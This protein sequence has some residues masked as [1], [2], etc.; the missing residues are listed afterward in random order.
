M[1]LLKRAP[2]ECGSWVWELDEVAPPGLVSA[3]DVAARMATI[4]TGHKLLEPAMLE[5]GW[6]IPGV[7]ALGITTT[8]GLTSPLGTRELM[9]RVIETRPVGFLDAEM[10]DFLVL[11]SGVWIDADGQSHREP[12]LVELSVSPAA[13]GLSA[14]VAVYHDIWGYYDFEG[15]P[16]PEIQRQNGRR[17]AAALRDLDSSLGVAAI[18]GEPTYFGSAVG[19]GIHTPD[20][21][22]DGLGPNLTDKL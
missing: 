19:Y 4:L 5:Y 18:P 11:G 14:E 3:L 7:G 20:P 9:E 10:D 1:S 8:V 17:L 2:R 12:R 15:R 21:T 13:I 6:Y 22:D 16:H